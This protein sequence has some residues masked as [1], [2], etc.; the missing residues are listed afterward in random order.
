MKLRDADENGWESSSQAWLNRMPETGDFAREF[1]L[2][3]PMLERAV[4]AKPTN[5]LDI[6][7]GDGRFCRMLKQ[8]GVQRTGIDPVQNFVDFA[9]QRD[10]E[11]QYDNGFAESLPYT[12]GEFDL[13]VFYL[14]LIDIDDM[15][16]AI[17]EAARVLR[18]NGTLLIANLTS[19]S[20]ANGSLGWIT[21]TDGDP[22][23]PIVNYHEPRRDWFEWGGL[24]IR[25]WHRPLSDYMSTLLENGMTLKYFD[26]PTPTGGT[27]ESIEKYKKNP[28][29]MM[30]EWQKC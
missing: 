28:F 14:I 11:G 24:R 7:C 5:M 22:F 16:Q 20:T 12:D 26:E 2:D 19:F 3:K 25:N 29:T 18:P 13:A 10:P 17:S 21:S 6:G 4:K 30:M 23:F 15:Q 27:P 8:Y 9:R 1:I